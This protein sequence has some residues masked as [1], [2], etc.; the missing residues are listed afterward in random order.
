[1]LTAINQIFA[2]QSINLAAQDLQTTP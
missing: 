1:V 2:A